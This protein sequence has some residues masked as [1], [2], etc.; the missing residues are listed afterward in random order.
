[1]TRGTTEADAPA[2]A[3]AA[4]AYTLQIVDDHPLLRL[5]LRTLLT[6]DPALRVVAE[7]GDG[8][9][10]LGCLRKHRPDA[11][12]LDITLP[13]GMDGLELLKQMHSE[14]PHLAVLVLSVHDENLYASRALAAGARG[15]LMKDA[16]PP[17]FLRAIQA[18]LAGEI[19]VSAA[20]T[21]RLVR[22]AVD[23]RMA[24]VDP[25]GSLSDR[26]LEVLFRIGRGESSLEIAGA[27][28]ISVKTVETHR[29]KLRR[30]LALRT[31][32][33]LMRY[34]VAW[35]HAEGRGISAGGAGGQD[36]P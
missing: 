2:D 12:I 35:R 18:V 14:A 15:Y 17:D 20:L 19:A 10:A 11:L 30:K 7:C 13:G 22:R 26:E 16:P 29:A 21:Q 34:A 33:E 1:M 4:K 27:L 32:A 25:S 31:A 3:F 5:G 23:S 28:H 8:A 6:R 9:C 36:A 24:P